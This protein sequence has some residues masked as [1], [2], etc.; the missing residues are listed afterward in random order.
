[1]LDA[2][3]DLQ[4]LSTSLISDGRTFPHRTWPRP[5]RHLLPRVSVFIA[6][7]GMDIYPELAHLI[8]DSLDGRTIGTVAE[9]Q[10]DIES[11][12]QRYKYIC[13]WM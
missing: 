5:P 6:I 7:K 1:M 12:W 8:A 4:K 3:T 9:R 10:V 11:V 2:S 13:G